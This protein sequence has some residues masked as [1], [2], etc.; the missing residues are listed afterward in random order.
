MIKDVDNVNVT[1]AHTFFSKTVQVF[2]LYKNIYT[3]FTWLV[4]VLLKLYCVKIG[5][6]KFYFI[7]TLYLILYNLN[8]ILKN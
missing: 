8:K 3:R 4:R 1:N 7:I 2:L 5:Y 6:L